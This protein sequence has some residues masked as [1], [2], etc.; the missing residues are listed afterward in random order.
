MPFAD[1]S[2][3]PRPLPSATPKSLGNGL[4]TLAP[5]SRRGHGPGMVLI[6]PDATDRLILEGGACTPL[7]KWAEEGYAVVQIES[8]AFD[9]QSGPDLLRKAVAELKACDGLE[10]TGKVGLVGMQA[11]RRT[12]LTWE[13]AKG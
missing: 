6:V 9:G 7:N 4:T 8:A 13:V 1:I 3:P 5:L 2:Q 12:G 11:W 10:D